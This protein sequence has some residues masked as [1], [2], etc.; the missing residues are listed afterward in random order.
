MCQTSSIF[1][2]CLQ[3]NGA[4]RSSG[5]VT[6]NNWLPYLFDK[7]IQIQTQPKL[8]EFLTFECLPSETFNIFNS[9]GWRL[10][11]T[12]R[13]VQGQFFE[14]LDRH[15]SGFLT[16]KVRLPSGHRGFFAEVVGDALG[17]LCFPF[18]IV[19]LVQVLCRSCRQSASYQSN[20]NLFHVVHEGPCEPGTNNHE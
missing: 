20:F 16:W 7:S 4:N 11:Q 9:S 2:H 14:K 5:Q 10:R 1:L 18:K 6:R 15:Q 19:V 3:G 13:L 12:H 8:H 17:W